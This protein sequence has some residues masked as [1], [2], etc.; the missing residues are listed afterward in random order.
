MDYTSYQSNTLNNKVD[1]TAKVPD[2]YGYIMFKQ[3][4]CS[5]CEN[6]EN[7]SVNM[8]TILST[9]TKLK[10]YSENLRQLFIFVSLKKLDRKDFGCED[11]FKFYVKDFL[12][13]SS[14]NREVFARKS[15]RS[16]PNAEMPQNKTSSSILQDMQNKFLVADYFTNRVSNKNITPQF[17]V[18]KFRHAN[19]N[20]NSTE[21][22]SNSQHSNTEQ[23]LHSSFAQLNMN[24]RPAK[25]Q[26]CQ[27]MHSRPLVSNSFENISVDKN[28]ML[29]SAPSNPQLRCSDTKSPTQ[30]YQ[31]TQQDFYQTFTQGEC[32]KGGKPNDK[33]D[34]LLS[35]TQFSQKGTLIYPSS[36]LQDMQTRLLLTDYFINRVN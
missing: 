26:T 28:M 1:K 24:S 27:N 16:V 5:K 13:C 2:K 33:S 29:G 32:K 35:N 3:Y 15:D 9:V 19:T 17:K 36:T 10:E 25:Q 11:C 34:M 14:L 8:K 18:P 4:H 20:N 12:Q 30:I 22:H 7:D 21:L 6:F 31:N 23:N